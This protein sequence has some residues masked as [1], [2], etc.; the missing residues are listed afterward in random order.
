MAPTTAAPVAATIART[1]NWRP[2]LA[3]AGLA[4]VVRAIPAALAFG[5]SDV[6]AWDQLA[7]LFLAGE[8][9]YAPQPPNWPVLWIYFTAGAELPPDAPGIPFSLLV[10]LPPIAADAAI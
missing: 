8:N 1:P 4:V 5:T 6:L 10:K 3:V 9:F 7:R 2:A